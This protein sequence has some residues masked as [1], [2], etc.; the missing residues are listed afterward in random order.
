VR[1][2]T[3]VG[4]LVLYVI[5]YTP[6]AHS[7][8]ADGL[9]L[10]DLLPSVQAA[11]CR[12]RVFDEHQV[13]I[14]SGSGFLVSEKNIA[15]CHHVFSGSVRATAE[16]ETGQ[17]LEIRAIHAEDRDRDLIVAIL[18]RPPEGIHPLKLGG[19]VKP[20]VGMDVVAIGYPLSLA[21]TVSRGI[22]TSL[23][24]GSDLNRSVGIPVCKEDDRFIQ[25]DAAVSPGNSGG[26]LINSDGN[27]IAVMSMVRRGGAN[28]GFG[29]PSIYMESM[30]RAD[31]LNKPLGGIADSNTAFDFFAP[32]IPPR[33]EK[34]SLNEVSR[35]I[36]RLR[37]LTYCVHCRGSGSVTQREITR[38]PGMVTGG[39]AREIRARC[40]VCR[41]RGFLVTEKVVAYN[42]L[43]DLAQAL[44]YLD[45]DASSVRP[46]QASVVIQA[47]L[48]ALDRVSLS[49]VPVSICGKAAEAIQNADK[50]QGVGICFVGEILEKV[51]AG[52]H[53]YFLVSLVG[54]DAMVAIVCE[55]GKYNFEGTYLISGILGGRFSTAN[56]PKA[57]AFVW[58]AF[59][60]RP[61]ES[62]YFI[63]P[64]GY[65]TRYYAPGD[66]KITIKFL[67]EEDSGYIPVK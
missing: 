15:S 52:N 27:V 36:G 38:Q 50:N 2:L 19:L 23:P 46:A 40:E 29:I 54:Y 47:L 6:L 44:V 33:K 14:G 28:L 55:G 20:T 57:L 61:S 39:D 53:D 58:P 45:T 21:Q 30:L 25:T 1:N 41:G 12:I 4:F 67:Q 24:K 13:P 62:G 3:Q 5:L 51:S 18:E 32:V 31:S 43:C 37:R 17:I 22:V 9:N 7:A 65:L 64:F 42:I 35:C 66:L 11:V 59:L 48:A 16:F 60:A 34:V 26:P 56:E 10:A 49:K 8:E 63:G